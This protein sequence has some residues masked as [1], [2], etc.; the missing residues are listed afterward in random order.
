M[1]PLP[2]ILAVLLLLSWSCQ[3]IPTGPAEPYN[4]P[5]IY[6]VILDGNLDDWQDQ[7][8]SVPFFVDIE[9][10]AD[11]GDFNAMVHVGWDPGG[12]YLAGSITDDSLVLSRRRILQNDAMELF[13]SC[14]AGSHRMVQYLMP[15]DSIETD[16]EPRIEKNDTVAGGPLKGVRDIDVSTGKNA[17]GYVF[18]VFIPF[19]VIPVDRAESPAMQILLNDSDDGKGNDVQRY[20]W[21]HCFNTYTNNN[22]LHGIKLVPAGLE[23]QTVPVHV[24][25]SL[26]DG[27]IY[28][29][30][31]TADATRIGEDISVRHDGLTIFQ[32]IMNA[33][34]GA[35]RADITLGAEHVD[36][37]VGQLEILMDARKVYTI[38]AGEVYYRF[39]HPPEHGSGRFE[40]EIR[41]HEHR[42]AMHPCSDSAV[43]FLGSSS[44]RLWKTVAEDFPREEVVPCGFGGSRT[45]DM[46]YYFDRIVAPFPYRKI[47]YFCGINDINGS[48]PGDTI[49]RNTRTFLERTRKSRPGCQVLLLSNTVSVSKK[50]HYGRIMELNSAYMELAG[51]F[52]HVTYVDV[53][54]PLLDQE[55]GIRPELYSADSTHMNPAGYEVWTSVLKKYL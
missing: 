25:A 49:V 8:L 20:A 35:A 23:K 11:T 45:A 53:T 42:V 55:G 13:V 19:D 54:T 47:V 2:A 21:H 34:D 30:I 16:G 26:V 48:V 37:V 32:G 1:K 50:H 40:N 39:T 41:L 33:S 6:N 36:P 14:Q 4:V 29:L 27:R 12:L 17:S 24:T 15:L 9:G 5:E 38:H 7:G 22:G 28:R 10:R 52:E 3:R 46:L 18:E 43:L 44:I 51:E 31:I